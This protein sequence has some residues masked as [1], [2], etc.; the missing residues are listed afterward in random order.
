[1][2]AQVLVL[3]FIFSL[4]LG[5]FYNVVALR[6]L[7]KESFVLPSSRCVKCNHKLSFLDMIPV[8]SYIFLG[9]KCRYCK[10]KVSPIY[11]IGELFTAVSYTVVI[12]KF[13]FTLETLIQLIFITI[14]V[15]AVVS[16]LKEMIVPNRYVVIG[17]IIVA[18]LR[19]IQGEGF[20][21]YLISGVI[22]FGILLTVLIISR[23]KMG[24]A[25]VK[26]YGLIGLSV[27]LGNSICSLFYASFLG[28]LY[29]ALYII[30]KLIKSRSLKLTEKEKTVPFVPFI[31][32][33]ILL[34]YIYN[35]YWYF[36]L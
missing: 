22:S 5:S 35:M 28:S 20:S 31:F 34:T 25:D 21:Y 8:F 26:L 14:M 19:F 3:V 27:G 36:G 17:V 15:F 1:M 7:K 11:P 4:F 12:W 29:F 16:D 6:T 2:T 32:I 9:G 10:E 30:I 33:G 23:G 18:L 24:G 13:G